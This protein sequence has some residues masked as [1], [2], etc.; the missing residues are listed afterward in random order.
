MRWSYSLHLGKGTA[1]CDLD[2]ENT[3]ALGLV[4]INEQVSNVIPWPHQ[5]S[6]FCSMTSD[7]INDLDGQ[8]FWQMM[9]AVTLAESR[10]V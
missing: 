3:I 4:N 1:V 9:D 5:A 10:T 6:R 7:L 2:I 8:I